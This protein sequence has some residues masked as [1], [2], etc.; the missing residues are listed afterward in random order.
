MGN[1]EDPDEMPHNVSF[2][3][4]LHCLLRQNLSSEKRIQ[5][6]LE[7]VTCDPSIY[8]MVHPDLTVSNFMENS[9]VLKRAKTIV[10]WQMI[11][12]KYYCSCY[13][14]VY[15]SKG[16]LLQFANYNIMIELY[17]FKC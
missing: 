1:S 4:G 2:H 17:L 11:H 13:V 12:M 9:I 15:F 5:Y 8:T 16:S 14:T 3:R 10:C 7:T 6:F